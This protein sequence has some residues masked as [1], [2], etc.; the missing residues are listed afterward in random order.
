MSLGTY[1]HRRSPIHRIPA[2]AK[3]LFLLVGG[4]LIFFV[5]QLYIAVGVLIGIMGLYFVAAIPVRILVA[6]IRPIFW[7]FL[8]VFLFQLF[9]RDAWFASMVVTRFVALILLA[10]LVT[11]TTPVSAMIEAIE[12]GIGW[13]RWFGVNPAKISLGFSLS[14]RFIPVVAKIASEVREAQRARGLEWSVLAVAVPVVIRTLKMA[15]DVANA[16]DARGYD[17]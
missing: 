5:Q 2:G 1:V 6:Q 7:I 8:L 17:P 13:L 12:K 15:D 4:T 16:I 11:L 3:V 10:S 9:T 14:L